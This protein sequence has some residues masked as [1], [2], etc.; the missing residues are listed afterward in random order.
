MVKTKTLNILVINWQDINNPLGGGAEVHCHEIFKRVAALGHRVT[1]LC[2]R[3]PGAATQEV[4][5]GITVIR[6][7]SRNDFNFH[8]PAAYRRLAKRQRFDIV[9][10]DINKIPFYT[11]LYVKEPVLAILHHLFGKSIYLETSC[12]PASYVYTSEKLVPVI[13][14]HTPFAVVSESTRQ[15]LLRLG[16]RSH[17]SLVQN[18]VDLQKYYCDPAGKSGEPLL[19]YLGRLKKYKCVDHIL[20]AMPEIIKTVPNARLLVI[21]GGDYIPHLEK[22]AVTLGVKERITFTGH[23]PHEQKIALLNS[24]TVCINPSPK[25]GWGRTVI[26]ANACGV[27]VVAADS[28]GLRDSVVHEK[29]GLLYPFGDIKKLA[30]SSIEILTDQKKQGILSKNS[31]NWV[32]SFSWEESAHKVIDVIYEIIRN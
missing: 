31:V 24:L 29:T 3:Y 6:C 19:G 12:I 20:C 9:V 23:V 4:I 5:D 18:A 27:P 8:V 28:P 15:E 22:L 25:E 32:R 10:D 2:C 14:K 11:P 17:I 30:Q 13:Y 7:G 1:L 26:E 16:I 21:G